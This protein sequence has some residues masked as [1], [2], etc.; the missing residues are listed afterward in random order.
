MSNLERAIAIA[1]LVAA[2]ALI[3]ATVGYVQGALEYAGSCEQMQ[4]R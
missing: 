3:G 2:S 4:A 1:I